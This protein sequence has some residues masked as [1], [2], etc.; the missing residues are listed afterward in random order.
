MSYRYFCVLARVA[1]PEFC[2]EPLLLGEGCVAYLFESPE[3]ASVSARKMKEGNFEF[4]EV[5]YND[6]VGLRY[7]RHFK[8]GLARDFAEDDELWV[9]LNEEGN[10]VLSAHRVRK[11]EFKDGDEY[12]CVYDCITAGL[13][14]FGLSS[15]SR[16]L[17]DELLNHPIKRRPKPG[18]L[19]DAKPSHNSC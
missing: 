1:H 11:R 18:E 19:C 9:P 15:D 5:W 16:V 13:H 14:S 4:L 7:S 3:L 12:D 10:P 17:R 8:N 2:V 6:Q